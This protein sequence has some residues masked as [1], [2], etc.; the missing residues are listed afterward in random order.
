MKPTLIE[1]V[2]ARNL[3]NKT[4]Q[5]LRLEL[6]EVLAKYKGKKVIKTTPYPGWTSALKKEIEE[7][8][9]HFPGFRIIFQFCSYIYCEIDK[10]FGIA[11]SCGCFYVKKQ[12]LLCLNQ[13]NYL[14]Q[15]ENFDYEFVF[16]SD[17]DASEIETIQK[18]IESKKAEIRS[19]ESQI[20]EFI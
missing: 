15:G 12:F 18:S 17:Y 11:G 8:E 7:I 19:L 13:D 4:A 14:S 9:D 16:K 6:I 2:N 1:E 10:S 3:V 20:Y 5:L